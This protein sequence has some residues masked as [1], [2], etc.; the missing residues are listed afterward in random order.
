MEDL[1]K[2]LDKFPEGA[3]AG[4]AQAR[5]AELERS[6]AALELRTADAEKEAWNAVAENIDKARIEAFLKDWPRG[7][8]AAEAKERIAALER[9]AETKAWNAVAESKD[10]ARI[11]AFLKDWPESKHAEAAKARIA[12][13][14]RDRLRLGALIGAGVAAV[15]I[16]AGW[17]AYQRGRLTPM[18]WDVSTSA[19]TTQAEQAL[20]PGK[21]FKEC[22]TCPDMVVVQTGSFT[23]GSDESD[24]EKRPHRVTIGQSFAVGK[25]EVTFDEWDACVAHG[26]CTWAPED[27]FWGRRRQPVMNVSWDDAKQYAAWIARLT[28]KPYRLLTEAEWEYAARGGTTTIYSWSNDIS[29]GNANCDGCGSQWDGKR[30]APV[31]SFKPNAFGL[32]DMHGNVEEWVEDCW[33]DTYAG[34]PDDGRAWT[35]SCTTGQRVVRGGSR[36]SFPT[37]LRS[38]RRDGLSA[39]LRNNKRGFRI[40]RTL[41]P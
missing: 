41:T 5:V 31:G 24:T 11:E 33:H 8:H 20:R 25:F 37:G 29:N 28:G 12:E 15:L 10:K 21:T 32:Y 7:Q 18:F 6:V 3:N 30:T 19:L 23:M 14:R 16:F 35:T 39:E 22:A 40:A 2:Y 27:R 1:D 34:A 13:L 36:S 26:G 17:L 9:N 4:A 38:T